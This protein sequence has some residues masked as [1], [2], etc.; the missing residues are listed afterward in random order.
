[1][2]AGIGQKLH[3]TQIM[4]VADLSSIEY[5]VVGWLA[6]EPE[7]MKVLRE[8]REVYLNFAVLL[9]ASKNLNYD[10]LLQRYKA[11]DKEVKLLR[12]N[13]K[14]P[15][16]GCGFKLGGGDLTINQFGDQVRTGLWGY[17]KNV[18]GIDMPRD[19]AHEAVRVYREAYPNVVQLWADMER[20]FK[21]VL[22]D[23]GRITVGEQTWNRFER[24][25]FD[26][27]QIENCDGAKIT[28]SRVKTKSN[29]YLMRMQLPSGRFLNYLNAR[30]QKETVLGTDGRPYER[31]AIIYD[32]IEHSSTT[33]EEGKTKKGQT[34]WGPTRSHGGKLTEN[35]VQAIA[36]D[37]LANGIRLAREMG[38]RIFALFHDEIA[39]LTTRDFGAPELEDLLYCMRTNPA[40]APTL[41]LEAAGWVGKTYHKG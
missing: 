9:Y 20:G 39:A 31:E 33:D 7:I 8:K 30:L 28:F 4:V 5:G 16:L 35:S 14:P 10:D 27:P 18:C 41:P 25:W 13:S 32:G 38:F 2:N 17:A 3:N 37:I 11:G 29:G 21:Q 40:W 19:L 12:Q 22:K 26:A 6:R 15:V 24:Q 23:G 36:R 34:K 1:M